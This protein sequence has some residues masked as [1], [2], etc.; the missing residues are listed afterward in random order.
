MGESLVGLI[1]LFVS[2]VP[3]S[4]Q[5]DPV[6]VGQGAVLST[7]MRARSNRTSAGRSGN[8]ARQTSPRQ[9]ARI[10]GDLPDYRARFGASDSRVIAL[11][12]ACRQGGYTFR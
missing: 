10:C 12:R 8:S 11:T 3:A 7:M 2:S 4:A 9:A 6:G 5:I 1:G